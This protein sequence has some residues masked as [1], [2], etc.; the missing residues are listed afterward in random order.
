MP[1]L[2]VNV[3]GSV[4]WPEQ[5]YQEFCLAHSDNNEGVYD[6]LLSMC[7]VPRLLQ[8]LQK[9]QLDHMLSQR[10]RLLS[11][12]SA[13]AAKLDVAVRACNQT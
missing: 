9:R 8:E 1:S 12:L 2:Q 7:G 11:N 6:E 3:Q 13:L 5:K 10:Q 4:D